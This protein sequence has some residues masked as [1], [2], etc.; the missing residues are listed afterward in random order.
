[1]N[2]RLFLLC[3]F[4]PVSFL[5]TSLVAGAA[6]V[7]MPNVFRAGESIVFIGDSITHGGRLND[8][9]HYLGHGYQAEIAM[10]YLAYC[11]ELRLQFENRGISGN[12]SSN[13][14]N[15]WKGD[16]VPCRAGAVGESGVF[17][18]SNP[19]RTF[20]PDVLNILVGINDFQKNRVSADGYERNLRFMVTNSLALN[21]S[22]RIVICEP[23]KLPTPKDESFL[24]YQKIAARVA[25][26]YDC[27]FVPFQRLFSEELI[28]IVPREKYWFWDDAHPTYAAH[29]RMADFWLKTVAKAFAKDRP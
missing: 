13:L 6:E 3:T 23:F 8:M 11:P 4:V 5:A 29:M 16:A 20:M 2:C 27:I 1:M 28:S 25:S 10:R 19:T 7:V 18:W 14:V 17:G 21:P 9:N 26:D 15:R 24:D 22:M 12:T